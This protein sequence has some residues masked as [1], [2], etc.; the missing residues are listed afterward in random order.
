[1]S[2]NKKVL[3]VYSHPDVI[4][5]LEKLKLNLRLFRACNASCTVWCEKVETEYEKNGK[6]ET[7]YYYR[8]CGDQIDMP[9]VTREKFGSQEQKDAVTKCVQLVL[10]RMK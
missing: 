6:T 1:M 10:Q 3:T 4:D 9:S 5:F 7:G 8:P 2:S